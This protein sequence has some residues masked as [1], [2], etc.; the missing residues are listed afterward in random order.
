M[1]DHP[2]Y[3]Y[4]IRILSKRDYSRAKL[5]NK[6]I[7]KDFEDVADDLIELLVSKKLLREDF[8]IES[9][10]KG[11]M[12]K[13]YSSSYIKSKLNE[14]GTQVSGE[15]IQNIF[16]EWGY[17]G[18]KQIEELIRKKSILHNWR[19]EDY[20]DPNNRPKLVRFIQSKGHNW[21]DLRDFL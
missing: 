13:N 8:Y 3:K 19:G 10:I 12:K 2:A 18:I 17:T 11:M 14:E 4:A 9:K 5:K 20:K 16:E 21:E 15:M 6:L 1:E 7:Q